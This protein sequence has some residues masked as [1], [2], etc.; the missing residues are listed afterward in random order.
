MKKTLI[1]TAVFVCVMA[2]TVGVYA[3]TIPTFDVALNTIIAGIEQDIPLPKDIRDLTG[4]TWFPVVMEISSDRVSPGW[5]DQ[6]KTYD[7]V[8]QEKFISQSGSVSLAP[9]M[10]TVEGLRHLAGQRDIIRVSSGIPLKSEAPLDLSSTEILADQVW[11][12]Y[13]QAFTYVRGDGIFISV[14][15]TGVDVFHPSLFRTDPMNTQYTWYDDGSGN[16]DNFGNDWVDLNGDATMQSNEIL[17]FFDGRIT[18]WQSNVSNNN[19]FYDADVDWLYNDDNNNS[20]RDYG[21]GMF[22]E[23]QPSLGEMIFIADDLDGDNIL[24]INEPLIALD[25]SKVMFTYNGDTSTR[26][27][28]VDLMLSD[29]DTVGHGTEVC[30]ILSG[31]WPGFNRFTGVAP[32]AELM[33]Y[34]RW[35]SGG[36][37]SYLGWS[38]YYGAHIMLWEL[39]AWTGYYMDG[40]DV[41]DSYVDAGH[42]AGLVQVVPAGNLAGCNRHGSGTVGVGSPAEYVFVWV[43]AGANITTVYLT[44]LWPNVDPVTPPTFDIHDQN[45]L[46]WYMNMPGDSTWYTIGAGGTTQFMSIRPGA[47]SRGTAMMHV[48]IQSTTPGGLIPSNFFQINVNSAAGNPSFIF[49][50]YTADDATGWSGGAAISSYGNI[51]VTDSN[52]I[53]S[54]ATADNAITVASYSTRTDGSGTGSTTVG[55]ASWFSGR[56]PRITGNLITDV[57]APGDYDVYS[58]ASV[59]ES[60]MTFIGEYREF[61]G[62]SAA[63]PHVAGAAALYMQFDPMSYQGNPASVKSRIQSDAIADGFTGSVPND[64]WGYG[65]LRVAI[66]P[67]Y[68]PPATP[69]PVGTY[70][71]TPTPTVSEPTP[72]PEPYEFGDAPDE[73]YT[74]TL[75]WDA[76]STIPGMQAAQF[77][78]CYNTLFGIHP[79]GVH[80]LDPSLGF[81]SLVGLMPSLEFDVI[82]PAD[83][84]TV[85]NLDVLAMI[86]D[87]D[88]GFAPGPPDDGVIF[89]LGSSPSLTI[90]ANGA[91]VFIN[92]L[93]DLNQN[94]IWEITEH[95]IVEHNI[96]HGSPVMIP[97][98]TLGI[99]GEVWVRVTATVAPMFAYF[100]PPWDGSVPTFFTNGETEDYL[101]DIPGTGTPT[102]TPTPMPIPVTGAGSLAILILLISGLLAV[103][104]LRRR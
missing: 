31:G 1:S 7:V 41:M 24:D 95:V 22:P 54:P 82:D 2:M 8:I 67:I 11:Y 16:I 36:I 101:I 69:T 81:L 77:P 10:A 49:H 60:G 38:Q 91:P 47:S 85:P 14:A 6:L 46:G 74:G 76:Y 86:A 65:K 78:T 55:T 53:T 52:T 39:G 25:V 37:S 5:I 32:G 68:T 20:V 102:P 94:G 103:P 61:G 58:P 66:T 33:M 4:G 56:G 87:Q 73:S 29:Q 89:N 30:G 71:P 28:G 63:G 99:T 79:F 98:P 96:F 100:P 84:D 62:T 9:A 21:S 88:N 3:E 64:T 48:E 40:S 43:P 59:A 17:R 45:T 80:H 27:N 15:D 12:M 97:L 50:A 44:M 70:T 92:V 26:A 93:M 19:F 13:D 72:L 57:A 83:P 104:A 90:Q 18:D 51:V 75:V 23:S 34:N 35:T 42:S